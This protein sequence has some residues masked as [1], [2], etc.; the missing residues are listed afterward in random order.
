MSKKRGYRSGRR[1]TKAS[2]T[3]HTNCGKVGY[4]SRKLADS[5]AAVARRRTEE[6]I[7]VYH[8]TFCGLWHIGHPKHWKEQTSW[9]L[10]EHLRK[11]EGA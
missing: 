5:K 10:H 7:G 9:P 1:A 3:V 2:P 4:R 8:C 6:P 11:A